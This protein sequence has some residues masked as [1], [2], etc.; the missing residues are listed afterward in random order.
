MP[1]YQVDPEQI[2]AASAA[3]SASVSRI[4][5]AVAGM[6]S[7]LTQLQDVWHGGAAAQFTTVSEQWKQAQHQMELSL[8]SI[9]Q[10]LSQASM[11]Y[12]DAEAQATRLFAS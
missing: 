10:A 12:S 11:V 7:S 4:R 1:Q 9:Q 8:E 6:Y 2:Q 3:V 5:E